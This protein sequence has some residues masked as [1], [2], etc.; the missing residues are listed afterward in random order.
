M[1]DHRFKIA[2]R[3]VDLM[4]RRCEITPNIRPRSTRA[5]FC[6]QRYSTI[7]PWTNVWGDSGASP[8]M[9]CRDVAN[10]GQDGPKLAGVLW[11]LSR[12]CS[13]KQLLGDVWVIG[14][15]PSRGRRD[16]ERRV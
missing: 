9:F 6:T 1:P 15:P 4:G 10:S 8:A 5:V 14:E 2:L 11:Q 13:G 7:A 16:G 12:A 3:R